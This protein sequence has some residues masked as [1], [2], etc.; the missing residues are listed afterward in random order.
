[1]TRAEIDAEITRLDASIADAAGGD[2][3]NEPFLIMLAEESLDEVYSEP[4]NATDEERR[5]L[6]AVMRRWNSGVG[7]SA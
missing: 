5:A 7:V 2:G 4:Q 6:L 3:F 1:V